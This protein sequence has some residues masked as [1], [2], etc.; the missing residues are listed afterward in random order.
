MK[1]EQLTGIPYPKKEI[2]NM[3]YRKSLKHYQFYN[4][5]FNPTAKIIIINGFTKEDTESQIGLDVAAR[6]EQGAGAVDH[7][8]DEL[9]A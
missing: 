1:P 8:R 4:V 2:E 6:R 9:I 5:D 3:L 7:P